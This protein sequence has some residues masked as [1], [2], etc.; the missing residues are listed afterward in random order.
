MSKPVKYSIPINALTPV[1]TGD[2]DQK[3]SYIK[4]TSIL[5]GL[6][7]WTEALMRTAGKE[8]CDI[9]SGNPCLYNGDLSKICSVCNFFGCTGIGRSFAINISNIKKTKD[10][11]GKIQ[12]KQ[13]EYEKNGK[14]KIPT[15]PLNKKKGIKES[16]SLNLLPLRPGGITTELALSLVLMLKWGTFGAADQ[17]GYGIVS[18]EFPKEIED[19]AQK[20]LP[21]APLS[22][23]HG[24][25]L[26]DFF[27]FQATPQKNHPHIPFEIRYH[28]RQGLRI[29]K[30]EKQLRHYFCGSIEKGKKGSRLATKYNLG[31][32]QSNNT[33]LITG[34]GYFPHDGKFSNEKNRCLDLL[35]KHL[36]D[37]STNLKWREFD[38]E[39]DTG[40]KVSDV[41]MYL[42]KLLEGDWS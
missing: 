27:F 4:G 15:W 38:S 14:T 1:W 16:F 24:L 6:R 25:T 21:S 29:P 13:Y 22:V 35:K 34:W 18:A 8:V 5:G 2:A 40:S 31:L 23:S 28:V 7:F 36:E 42:K 32:Y 9:N 39:R 3:T 37:Y 17:F 12:L 10:S 11:L 41:P 26:K 20:A 19:L 30:D 33:P